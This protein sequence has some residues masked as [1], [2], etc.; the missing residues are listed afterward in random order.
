MA[1]PA[2]VSMVATVI[3]RE[4][5]GEPA[6]VARTIALVLTGLGIAV[7]QRVGLLGGHAANLIGGALKTC[8]KIREARKP[9]AKKPTAK[10]AKPR[11]GKNVISFPA[12]EMAVS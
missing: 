1:G 7:T 4:T 12:G 3:A 11:L 10:A 6:S 2:E 8:P 5:G 9:G